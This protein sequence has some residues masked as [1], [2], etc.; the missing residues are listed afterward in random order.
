MGSGK[1]R[2]IK[3]GRKLKTHRIINRYDHI[4]FTM[5]TQPIDGQIRTTI[6][7]IQIQSGENHSKVHLTQQESLLKRSPLKPNN[8][9]LP[10]E[11]V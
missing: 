8:Q 5:L 10:S 3:A 1:P 9:T 2:G 7:L 4:L 11:S 6:N